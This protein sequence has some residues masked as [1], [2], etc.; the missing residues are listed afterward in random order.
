MICEDVG[1]GFGA[2]S[3]CY[4]EEIVLAEASRVLGH[5]VKWVEDRR[6][7]LLATTHSRGIDVALELGLAEDGR[8]EALRATVA[9]DTGA[10][11]FTSGIATG[12]L[13]GAR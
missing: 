1:G 4:G 6:E 12:E 11:V 10:Y 13:C 9:L 7:N 8:F 5:P 2:K 3:R